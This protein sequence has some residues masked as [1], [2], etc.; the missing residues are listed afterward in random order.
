MKRIVHIVGAM[1]PG[2][3]ENFI[4]N[5]YRNLNRDEVQ[6]DVIVH[7]FRDGDYCDE[8]RR[9]GGNV[10]L[11]P[12]KSKHPIKNFFEIK[13]IIKE[14]NIKVAVR[15]SDSSFSVLDLLAAKLGGAERLIYQ[16][17][18]SNTKH[19]WIHKFFRN[20]MG[21]IPTDRFACSDNAGKWMYG[22]LDYKVVKNA[23]DIDR[24]LFD[25]EKREKVRKKWNMEDKV[26]YSHV[27]IYMPAKNHKFLIEFFSYIVKKQP[28][29]MLILIGE[30][31]LRSEMEAQILSLGIG[32]NVILTG[33]RYDVD[34]LLQMTDVFLFPSIYEGL[35][36]SII[37]AQSAGLKCLISDVITREVIVTDLVTQMSLNE[38]A[39]KWADKAIELSEEAAM[40]DRRN[41]KEEVANAGYDVKQL[42]AWYAKL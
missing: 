34:E 5:I 6:F 18:S 21:S 31:E 13:R 25:S 16:S 2:G 22:N 12:R 8:I 29:A 35:P 39:E 7:S 41:T 17:H 20:F 11:A 26:V 28:N 30:G 27:G 19:V 15:H 23:I 4:M 14:N 32:D 33:V 42:A 37:E 9:L 3:L 40:Y 10:Y 38:S 36:L 1:Y 24:Y